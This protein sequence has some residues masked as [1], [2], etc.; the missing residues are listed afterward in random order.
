[1]LIATVVIR[2]KDVTC[3]SFYVIIIYT[4]KLLLVTTTWQEDR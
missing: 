4:E 2:N 3:I 1:M